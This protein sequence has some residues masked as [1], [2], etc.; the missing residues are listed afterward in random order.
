M[1]VS[2]YHTIERSTHPLENGQVFPCNTTPFGYV[3]K[4]LGSSLSTN[5]ESYNSKMGIYFPF[6]I[7]V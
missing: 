1:C 5:K 3:F 4:D 6:A 7:I 2:M